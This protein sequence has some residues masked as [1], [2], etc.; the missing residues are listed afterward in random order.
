MIFSILRRIHC[1]GSRGLYLR[2]TFPRL[3][4]SAID[5]SIV[6]LNGSGA[7]WRESDH[8][9]YFPNGSVLE[10]GHLQEEKNVFDYFSAEYDD[11]CFDEL[12]EF[13]EHMYRMLLSRLRTTKGTWKTLARA[14]TNPGGEGHDWVKRR[15]ITPTDKGDKVA[16]F[17]EDG[18]L[19]RTIR[20]V[21]ASV[22]DNTVLL[23]RDPKYVTILKSLPSEQRAM[24][25]DGDWDVAFEGRIFKEFNERLHV[26]DEPEG[27]FPKDWPL[28]AGFDYGSAAPTACIWSR[29]DPG[30]GTYWVLDEH[31]EVGW[32]I[33]DITQSILRRGL[34][35]IHGD[36][37]I[38]N[39]QVR[40]IK[41][42]GRLLQEAGVLVYRAPNDW[43]T[44]IQRIRT[45]LAQGRLK[46]VK[47]RCPQ[48][49]REIG[50]LQ[51]R[52]GASGQTWE[53]SQG[54]DH[55]VDALRY[56][57]NAHVAKMVSQPDED[58]FWKQGNVVFLPKA[59]TVGSAVRKVVDRGI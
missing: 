2:R 16:V 30:T 24:L 46:F 15:F 25:L 29:F 37:A 12:T 44:S 48:L 57:I 17:E 55:A 27:G 33:E 5:R 36:P 18:G 7:V 28:V 22:Y 32:T 42:I 51:W 53:D 49:L 43:A 45:L 19:T 52:V 59:Y 23:E 47:D 35:K 56:L 40:G 41:T 8:A 21:P 58:L 3:R 4:R 9:W 10:F 20:F 1:P 50:N 39:Y 54:D 6:L 38:W 31:Y 13:S 14:A 11:I 34:N 26:V